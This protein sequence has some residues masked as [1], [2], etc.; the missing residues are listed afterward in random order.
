METINVP[1]P[2]LENA[3][4]IVL[5]WNDVAPMDAHQAKELTKRLM[6]QIEQDQENK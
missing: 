5:R 6:S 2:S 4:F 3:V 1:R